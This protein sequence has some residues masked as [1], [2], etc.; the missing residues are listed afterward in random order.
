M[1]G[2][3][4]L[5]LKMEDSTKPFAHFGTDVVHAGQDPDQ[6]KCKALVP[7]VFTST[8]FKQDEPGQPV[9]MTL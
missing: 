2:G 1:C 4:V 8:T 9:S 5:L 6:W 3:R 7:P